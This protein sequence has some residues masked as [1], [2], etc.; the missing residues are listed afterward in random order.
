MVT[1]NSD[2][3]SAD[4]KTKKIN[5]KLVMSNA[6]HDEI[7]KRSIVADTGY[8]RYD[9]AIYNRSATKQPA[10]SLDCS[11]S[12]LAL[13]T[14]LDDTELRSLDCFGWTVVHKA[15]Y[16]GGEFMREL[17]RYVC[18]TRAAVDV[19]WRGPNNMT[20]LARCGQAKNDWQMV[21]LLL[22]CGARV[23]ARVTFDARDGPT[24]LHLVLSATTAGDGNWHGAL[25]V[26]TL[27]ECGARLALRV[28]LAPA[29]FGGD[30][31]ADV[32]RSHWPLSRADPD[33]RG[34]ASEQSVLAAYAAARADARD[35]RSNVVPLRWF[36]L[37]VVYRLRLDTSVFDVDSLL[38]VF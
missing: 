28:A 26:S 23:D 19:N 24:A 6:L 9:S 21:S 7:R 12:L 16:L 5:E 8:A 37:H 14:I 2:I 29:S 4:S 18:L 32:Q 30:G 27:L 10:P 25:M 3:K 34:E 15:A 1:S 35:P 20:A 38:L 13:A 31:V 11:G 33:Q 22:E 17:V 36:C